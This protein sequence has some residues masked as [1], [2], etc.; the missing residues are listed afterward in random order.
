MRFCFSLVLFFVF[1]VNT[2]SA[3]G[4]PFEIGDTFEVDTIYDA[5]NEAVLVLDSLEEKVI[6]LNFWMIG[7][8]GCVEEMPYLNQLYSRYDPDK[9]AFFSV[10]MNNANQLSGFLEKHPIDWP[11]LEYVDFFGLRGYEAFKINCMP[12]TLIID[13]TRM[14][15]YARCAPLV[16]DKY[17]YTFRKVLEGLLE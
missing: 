1:L 16:N 3:Q 14:V 2:I 13:K 7:C 11:I 6:V 5:N 4:I 17:A 9:V 8:K 12:T 10:T 15:K